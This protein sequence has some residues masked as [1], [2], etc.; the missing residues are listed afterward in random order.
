MSK[1]LEAKWSVRDSRFYV[2]VNRPMKSQLF[3]FAKLIQ[4]IF[5]VFAFVLTTIA[6]ASAQLFETRAKQAMLV[7]VNSNSILFSK[8][9]DDQ[10]PPASL[11]K[12][13]TM[14]VVFNAL[15]SG[16]LTLDDEFIVSENAWR[17][18]G[19]GSGGSTMFAELNSSIRLEDLIKG[20]IVQS[21]NDGC[22]IIAEG[23]AGSEE[24][25]AQLMTE[26]ARKIG[27]TNSVFFNSTG[28]P[29]PDQKITMRDLITL[30]RHLQEEYPVYFGYYSLTSFEWNNINQRN[31]NPLLSMDIGADG[32]KTG[33]T[34]ASGYAIVGSINRNG[35]RLVVAMSGL[36]NQRQRAEEARKM[37]QWGE[38]A[39][40]PFKIFE[41]GDVVGQV[42]LYGG[43]QLSVGVAPRSE[44]NIMVPLVNRDRLKAQVV[45][46]GPVPTPVEEGAQIAKL[47]VF[48]GD[49]L[50]QE[51]P[52][53][54]TEDVGKGPIH[55]QALDALTELFLGWIRY[56]NA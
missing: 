30:T 48:I 7:D 22:I 16:Q 46:D 53:Y 15:K 20:V 45:Y 33:F 37:L 12:L 38:R 18:G 31:R 50:A 11:A 34:E 8:N 14:E 49:Q 51:A 29:H 2:S 21:A 25:F 56:G 43:A 26:R 39:F 47:R 42:R 5:L 10:I 1:A 36:E 35:R 17:T 44:L 52:L 6:V 4:T 32:M 54:A 9:A 3:N 13:M 28:L 55:R 23:M 24:L 19:A 40:E 27:L 41:A